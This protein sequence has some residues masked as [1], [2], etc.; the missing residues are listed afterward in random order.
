MG[1]TIVVNGLMVT[2]ASVNVTRPRGPLCRADH[3]PESLMVVSSVIAFPSRHQLLL[4]FRAPYEL[5]NPIY[6]VKPARQRA[7]NVPTLHTHLSSS[8]TRFGPS[9]FRIC[10]G[11]RR[12]AFVTGADSFSGACIVASS[13]VMIRIP[14]DLVQLE[15]AS[16]R[17][18][19]TKLRLFADATW[20]ARK[21]LSRAVSTTSS[22][23]SA[24]AL[25]V[26]RCG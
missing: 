26:A 4:A 1:C 10:G 20:S 16:A 17:L 22:C 19:R 14:G 15:K 8:V 3:F 12:P 21:Q 6:R 13:N 18:G 25:D 7:Y 23:K 5:Q 24:C 11:T 2:C 9:L